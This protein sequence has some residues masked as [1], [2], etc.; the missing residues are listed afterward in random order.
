MRDYCCRSES[1]W[2][3]NNSGSVSDAAELQAAFANASGYP[4][5]FV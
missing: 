4:E 2:L 1:G 5:R 3:T